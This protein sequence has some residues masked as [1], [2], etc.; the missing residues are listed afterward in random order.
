MGQSNFDVL[1]ANLFLGAQVVTQGNV[2]HV[3][4]YS[5]SDGNNGKSAKKAFKTLAKAYAAATASQNDVI[6]FYGEGDAASRCTDYQSSTANGSALYWNKDMVH[7]IG[8]NSGTRMS[9]R[10]RIGFKSTFAT[11]SNLFKCAAD[12]CYIANI[13]FWG[14]LDGSANPTG[15]VEVTGRMNRFENCHMAGMNG[16]AAINDIANAYSLKLTG[17]IENEFRNCTIGSGSTAIGANANA[18]IVFATLVQENLFKDCVICMQANSATNH[19]F[20]RSPAG[21]QV[22]WNI[23]EDCAFLNYGTALT[24]GMAVTSD[25]GGTTLLKGAGTMLYGATD[26]NNDSGTVIAGPI[27]FANNNFGFSAAVIKT[28]P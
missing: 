6:Y 5:G 11:A 10:A 16:A 8:V 15:C 18:Q 28:G 21:S 20:L 3:K 14:G 9:P 17:A 27:G 22:V 24:Y 7:L 1:K 2:F 25:S 19:L 26:W 13:Q 12:S 4:P 23:F